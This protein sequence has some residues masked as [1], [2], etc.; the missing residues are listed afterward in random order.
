MVRW[1]RMF[2]SYVFYVSFRLESVAT[3]YGSVWIFA[4]PSVVHN[5]MIKKL[6]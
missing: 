4:V 2:A 6:T 3:L 1:P 5:K